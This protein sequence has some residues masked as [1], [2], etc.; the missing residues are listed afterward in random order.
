MTPLRLARRYG[1]V[2]ISLTFYVKLFQAKIP[3]A[4][5]DTVDVTV[6]FVLMESTSVKA[7]CKILM[8]LTTGRDRGDVDCKGRPRRGRPS[9]RQEEQR[10][11]RSSMDHQVLPTSVFRRL[12]SKKA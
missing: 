5:K 10:R 9:D 8:K 4:Q 3:K 6:F 1:Q 2:S 11:C 7:E 12:F